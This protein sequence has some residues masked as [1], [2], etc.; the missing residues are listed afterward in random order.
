MA[1]GPAY[2][3]ESQRWVDEGPEATAL[4]IQQAAGELV[5]LLGVDGWAYAASI[6]APLDGS[7]E[8]ARHRLHE[9]S[10]PGAFG[11]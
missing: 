11:G 2:N 1:H 7:I 8:Q 6:G 3:Y 5:T 9:L 4:L 10:E